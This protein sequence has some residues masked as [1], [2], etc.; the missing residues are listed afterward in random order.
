M[1]TRK[2]FKQTSIVILLALFIVAARALN[3]KAEEATENELILRTTIFKKENGEKKAVKSAVHALSFGNVERLYEKDLG[4]LVSFFWDEK[5]KLV[6]TVAAKTYTDMFVL[7]PKISL[8]EILYA[9]EKGKEIKPVIEPKTKDKRKTV[10]TVYSGIGLGA[11]T[12]Y[13]DLTKE[14]EQNITFE[15][16]VTREFLMP[17]IVYEIQV[18]V[19]QTQKQAFY[20]KPPVMWWDAY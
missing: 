12:E 16:I 20:K 13:V 18:K 3:C 9:K 14:K 2:G 8:E 19:I 1:K 7:E 15:N 5:E 6:I 4:L 17:S 10:K 11:R